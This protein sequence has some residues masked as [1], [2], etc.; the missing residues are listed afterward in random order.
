MLRLA[1]A[2]TLRL[3]P[4][5]TLRLAPASQGGHAT[6]TNAP[7]GTTAQRQPTV[8]VQQCR[9]LVNFGVI[10]RESAIP[11]V[12]LWEKPLTFFE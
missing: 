11:D 2:A 9:T 12:L 7:A 3:A 10:S 5:T 8:T 6:V 1:P 4:A